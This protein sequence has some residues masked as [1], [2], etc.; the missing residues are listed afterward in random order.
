MQH[1]W[2]GT[3]QPPPDILRYTIEWKAVMN[4][5]RIAMD[6]DEDV[7]LTP[8]AYWNNTLHGK[9]DGALGREFALQDRPDPCSTAVVVSVNKRAERDLTKEFIGLEVDWSVIAEKL[10]SWACYFGEGKRLLVRLTLRFRPRNGFPR[11]GAAG[12]GRQSAT[13]RM[14]HG[15]ALQRDAEEHAIGQGAHWRHVY[16]ILRCPGRALSKQSRLL[17]ERSAWRKALQAFDGSSETTG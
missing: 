5:K 9:I 3:T 7:F 10:E 6:T 2:D 15:Q 4:T 11:F 13:Q 8:G 14:R 17:L 16:S 12:R 1:E